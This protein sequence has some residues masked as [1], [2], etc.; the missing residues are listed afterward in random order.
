MWQFNLEIDFSQ[1]G[2]K[3]NRTGAFDEGLIRFD[4]NDKGCATLRRGPIEWTRQ[5]F[6]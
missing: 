1:S 6:K 2:E 3:M 4:W 5:K